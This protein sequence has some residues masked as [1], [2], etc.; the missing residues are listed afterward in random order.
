[1]YSTR[2]ALLTSTCAGV[3]FSLVAISLMTGSSRTTGSVS[4]FE[5]R[6]GLPSGEYASRRIPVGR[7]STI[8]SV[9]LC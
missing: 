5:G 8:A 7:N 2:Y 4:V 1:M 6:L 3:E 9:P